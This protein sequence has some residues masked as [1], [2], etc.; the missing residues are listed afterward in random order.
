MK[1]CNEPNTAGGKK[2]YIYIGRDNCIIN[3]IININTIKQNKK[4]KKKVN[5]I[6][7][8]K[9]INKSNI[10]LSVPAVTTNA[11]LVL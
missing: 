3:L 10:S 2:L 5:K 9:Q 1:G 6:N 8:N 7:T 4:N 11:N